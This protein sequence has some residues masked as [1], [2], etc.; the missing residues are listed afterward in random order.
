MAGY[1]IAAVVL[2]LA[3]GVSLGVGAFERHMAA[4]EEGL[5]TLRY[6]EAAASLA[7][8]GRYAEYGRWI[9]GT[10]GPVA[11]ALRTREAALQYWQRQYDALL[12]RESD[13]VGAVDADNAAL[14]LLVADSAYRAVQGRAVG[15]EATIQLL[16]ET[17]AGYV[18]VLSGDTWDERAAYNYEYL[19]RVRDELARGRRQSLPPPDEQDAAPG[20]PGAPAASP[21]MKSFEIYIPLEGEERN[22]ASEAGKAAPNARK[23]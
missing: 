6:D 14:Q 17:I 16:D 7:E 20:E 19:V 9:P 4:A 3:G 11:R 12:P 5:V 8:A 13:P 22:K 18:T 2:A 1:L 10:G 23:G 15:R 21:D